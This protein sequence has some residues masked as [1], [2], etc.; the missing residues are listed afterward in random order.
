MEKNFSLGWRARAAVV[1]GALALAAGPVMSAPAHAAFPGRNGAVA[2]IRDGN[3]FTANG[4]GRSI[5]QVTTGGGFSDPTWSPDGRR[6]AYLDASGDVLVR[7]MSSGD[8]V[9]LGTAD[10][11]SRG[12]S[13]SGDGSRVAWVATLPDSDCLSQGIF[14]AP[15]NG[16]ATPTLL[17]DLQ[18]DWDFCSHA[19]SV[20]MGGWSPH[21]GV[22]SYTTCLVAGLGIGCEVWKLDVSAAQTSVLFALDCDTDTCT[23]PT[24]GPAKFGPGG[25][26]VVFSASGGDPGDLPGSGTAPRVFSV[27][28]GGSHLHQVSTASSGSDPTF[29]PNG[30]R[31]LF[32][33]DAG[34]TTSIVKSR[35]FAGSTRHVLIKNASQADWQAR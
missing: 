24:L 33:R 4:A 28:L 5:H 6:L 11:G 31:V 7:T 35:P 29:S 25:A 10:P 19:P 20:Q 30:K 34:S 8:T 23:I 12:P 26:K 32:T 16:G 3:V 13:W 14:A 17:Y 2:F 27:T 15:A 21:S 9:T 1:V 18:Q 22:I